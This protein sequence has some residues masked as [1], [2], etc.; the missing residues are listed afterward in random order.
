MDNYTK[1]ATFNYPEFIPVSISFLPA[2]WLKHGKVL[3]DVVLAHPFD[4]SGLQSR[5]IT[6]RLNWRTIYLWSQV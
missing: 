5:S 2:T 3:E 4:F 6:R 1:F